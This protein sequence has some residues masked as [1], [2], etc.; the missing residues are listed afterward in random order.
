M[1]CHGGRR[2]SRPGHRTACGGYRRHAP[3]YEVCRRPSGGLLRLESRAVQRSPKCYRRALRTGYMTFMPVLHPGSAAEGPAL[4]SRSSSAAGPTL[5]TLL[6]PCSEIIIFCRG[7]PAPVIDVDCRGLHV[8]ETRCTGCARLRRV[9][10]WHVNIR[11]VAV[12]RREKRAEAEEHDLCQPAAPRCDW[13]MV[14]TRRRVPWLRMA[15]GSQVLLTGVAPAHDTAGPVP[16]CCVGVRTV[17]G[18]AP[19]LSRSTTPSPRPIGVTGRSWALTPS[20]GKAAH[21]LW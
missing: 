17:A 9:G 21:S 12:Y 19:F 16:L 13:R 3:R 15:S 20:A 1:S 7:G 8:F 2:P 10:T 18:T 14:Q 6:R 4:V 11:T 5:L